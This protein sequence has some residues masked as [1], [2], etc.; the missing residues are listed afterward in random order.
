MGRGVACQSQE[1]VGEAGP[2]VLL[3]MGPL[4]PMDHCSIALNLH[5]L[6]C[7]IEIIIAAL[8]THGAVVRVNKTFCKPNVSIGTFICVPLGTANL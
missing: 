5:F 7:E 2:L 4:C 8:Y 6:V 1:S 3:C